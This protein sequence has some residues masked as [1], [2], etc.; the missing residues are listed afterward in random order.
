MKIRN[1]TLAIAGLI[2]PQLVWA[3]DVLN[4]V[5]G[6]ASGAY[7]TGS[8]DKY[9]I[10][11]LAGTIVNVALGMLGVL[12]VILIIYAGFLWMT[13]SGDK[14]KV[15]KSTKIIMASII[16]LIIIVAAYAIWNFVLIR[17]IL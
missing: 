17:I 7:N 4:K 12:F 6:V 16:G 13:S 9:S 8:T 15:D 14:E 2:L 1:I 3:G 5:K 10:S 11:N